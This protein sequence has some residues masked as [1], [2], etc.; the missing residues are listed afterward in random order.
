MFCSITC[1]TVSCTVCAD[2]PGYCAVMP[3]VGGA[4][5]GYCEIG[6][7][8]MEIPPASMIIMAITHAKTGRSIKKRAMKKPPTAS[9]K[10]ARPA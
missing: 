7:L 8:R 2:A 10:Q 4:M 9:R 3:M 6:R 5:D 1:V